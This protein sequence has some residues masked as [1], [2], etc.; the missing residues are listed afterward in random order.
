VPTVSYGQRAKLKRGMGRA[1]FIAV[2]CSARPCNRAAQPCS[3]QA[4]VLTTTSCCP[5]IPSFLQDLTKPVIQPLKAR[6][7]ALLYLQLFT[8][9][10]PITDS[11]I[12]QP[13][14]ILMR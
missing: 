11:L 3:P 4:P 8:K 10:L 7:W 12:L 14:V 2:G 1:L 5:C 6:T 13:F 9:A